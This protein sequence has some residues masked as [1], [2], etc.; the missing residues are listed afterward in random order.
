[1][2]HY[3]HEHEAQFEH[4]ALFAK[5]P[6]ICCI[7]S[8]CHIHSTN[9]KKFPLTTQVQEIVHKLLTVGVLLV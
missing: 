7:L 6:C 5:I 9:C 1:M 2:G 3:L 4:G 8:L